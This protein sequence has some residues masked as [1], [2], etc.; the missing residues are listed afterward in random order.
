MSDR[1]IEV[2]RRHTLACAARVSKNFRNAAS[3]PVLWDTLDSFYPIFNLLPSFRRVEGGEDLLQ[4]PDTK[5]TV[6]Y[7]RH[8]RPSIDPMRFNSIPTHYFVS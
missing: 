7:V 2:E 4:D 8:M 1:E 3:V 5:Y 6:L